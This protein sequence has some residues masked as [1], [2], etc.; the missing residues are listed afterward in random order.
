MHKQS[1][2]KFYHH[3][4]HRHVNYELFVTYPLSLGKPTTPPEG[5]KNHH[6]NSIFLFHVVSSGHNARCVDGT[7][8]SRHFENGRFPISAHRNMIQRHRHLRWRCVLWRLMMAVQ[9]VVWWT[10]LWG[11]TRGKKRIIHCRAQY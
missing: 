9:R 2:Q 8:H 3:S 6:G 1:N 10:T 4:L 5:C 11:M 7:K